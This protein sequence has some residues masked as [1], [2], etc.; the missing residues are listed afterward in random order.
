MSAAR[1]KRV[2]R[3]QWRRF[4]NVFRSATAS[5]RALPD[6]LIIGEAK[7]G[8][9]SL[10]NDL[11]SHPFVLGAAVKELHFFDLRYQRGI[12]WYKAQFPLPW[13]SWRMAGDRVQ[14]G[15]ASPYYLFHPHAPLRI[16]QALPDV[17]LIAML[18]NP[19]ERAY[20]HY[21][22]EFRKRRETLSFEEAVDRE[23]ERLRGE[24]ERMLADP[25]Y[26]SREHRR[27]AYVTRG[28]YVDPLHNVTRLF[29][30][31]RL[32]I[33]KSEDYFTAPEATLRRVFEFLELPPQ[34]SRSFARKNIG[35]YMPIDSHLRQRLVD[36]FAPHNA[37]LYDFIGVNLGWK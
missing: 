12:D 30:A 5:I 32:L 20:S 22:H 2:A 14:T 25:R 19:V 37:R 17:R 15:E 3:D 33:L 23:P 9:T 31:A 7:C 10:Y 24:L 21:Q 11:V 28:V 27:H 26:N 29:G 16:K 8:T 1:L 4:D 18:R 13:R 6:F 34:E 36:Y 35:S